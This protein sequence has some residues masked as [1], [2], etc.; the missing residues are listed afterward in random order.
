[1]TSWEFNATGPIEADIQ[2]A[3]GTVNVRAMPAGTVTVSLHPAHGAG[4]KAEKLIADTEVTFQDGTLT[5]HVPKRVQ[6][7]GN[8]SLDLTVELPEGSSVT[9]STA[10]ADVSCTGELG[11]LD[12]RTASGDVTADRIADRAELSTSSGALRLRDASGEV[13]LQSASGDAI[14]QRADGEITAKTASGD[15]VIGQAGASVQ[16]KTASGDVQID[17]MIAG[18]ADVTTVS[19]DVCV[20]VVPGIG[21][22]LDLSSVSGH[23]R[24]ELDSDAEGGSDG[25]TSLT[26]RCNSVSGDVTITRANPA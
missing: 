22:Y 17:S 24:S 13:R 11:S 9:V 20:G 6:L 10:S 4:G 15:L 25:D 12:G 21:V 14:I 19:G 18:Q 8:T 5:V 3:A 26:L 16:A 7:R 2:L 1:M 23:V